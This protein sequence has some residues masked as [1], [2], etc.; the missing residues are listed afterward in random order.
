MALFDGLKERIEAKAAPA[1]EHVR[2]SME[3]AWSQFPDIMIRREGDAL[4]LSGRGLMRR[5]LGDA[6]I[7]FASWS[8]R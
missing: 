5:W 7:R 1:A 4:V 6:R 2:R 3:R 8:R